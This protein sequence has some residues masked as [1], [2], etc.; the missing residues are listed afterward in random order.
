MPAPRREEPEVVYSDVI[1]VLRGISLTVT[2]ARIVALLGAN[3]AGKTTLLRAITGLL[4]IHR[5]RITKGTMRVAGTPLLR[6]AAP[7]IVR[8]GI[9]Q[10]MEGRRLFAELTVEENLRVGG[11]IH[12]DRRVVAA[13]LDRVFTLFPFLAERRGSVAGYLSGGEQQMV[14]IGRALM[15]HPRLLLLDEPS[16][17]LAPRIVEQVRDVILA[18]HREGTSVLLVEQNASMALPSRIRATSWRTA[19]SCATGRRRNWRP[20]VMSRSSI[21]AGTDP[22]ARRIATSRPTGARSGGAPDGAAVARSRTY[23]PPI[24]RRG[25]TERRLVHG[26]ARRAARD[27]RA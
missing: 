13:G 27:H 15:S 4:P 6:V 16:L 21:S 20:T 25:R 17:G 2:A 5:G 22:G 10:V 3:G 14:A 23:H 1:L 26:G 12:R 7:E 19:R 18:I 9:A 24:W 8:L 11:F